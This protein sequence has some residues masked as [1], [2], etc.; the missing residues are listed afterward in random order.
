MG[1]CLVKTE[2]IFGNISGEFEFSVWPESEAQN[3]SWRWAGDRDASVSLL[4]STHS[5]HFY[6]SVY[7]F[8]K[9]LCPVKQHGMQAN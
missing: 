5:E 8:T 4:A 7:G 3:N 1:E 6:V 9:N 2:N